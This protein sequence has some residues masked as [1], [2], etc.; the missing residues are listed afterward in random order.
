M[1]NV[2]YLLFA[3]LFFTQQACASH[4]DENG[5]QNPAESCFFVDEF[6]T[7]SLIHISE[8]TRR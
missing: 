6:E 8:P 1:K 7:L 4:D 2:K 5:P 3:F